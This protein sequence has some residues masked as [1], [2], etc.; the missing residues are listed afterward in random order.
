MF[1]KK[2]QASSNPS[3]TYPTNYLTP[4]LTKKNP[5]LP[6]VHHHIPPSQA[7]HNNHPSPT[8]Q[9]ISAP[10]PT[11]KSLQTSHGPQEK[12]TPVVTQ[13]TSS[14]AE[15]SNQPYA[16]PLIYPCH[17]TNAF[18]G[19]GAKNAKRP[20]NMQVPASEFLRERGGGGCSKRVSDVELVRLWLRVFSLGKGFFWELLC[21]VR[22]EKSREGRE[23]R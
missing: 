23:R 5:P 18:G 11:K 10:S 15:P 21:C 17:K 6:H 19:E 14:S 12:A 9:A 22:E 1:T 4:H 16:H 7:P 3:S 13:E 20:A 8:N 2:N